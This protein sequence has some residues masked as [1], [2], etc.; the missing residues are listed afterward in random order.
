MKAQLSY[1]RRKKAQGLLPQLQGHTVPPLSGKMMSLSFFSFSLQRA[2]T[3]NATIVEKALTFKDK[4]TV[5]AL[6][7]VLTQLYIRITWEAFG[8]Y[9]CTQLISRDSGSLGLHWRA[10]H[11]LP[12]ATWRCI[13][14]KAWVHGQLGDGRATLLSFSKWVLSEDRCGG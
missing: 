11:L 14:W 9:K 1:F 8:K 7:S 6:K 3:P 13:Q 2:P 5:Y 4:R 12:P 10:E